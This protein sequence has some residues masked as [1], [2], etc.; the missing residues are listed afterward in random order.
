MHNEITPVPTQVVHPWKAAARTAIQTAVA[1]LVFL[2]TAIP[3]LNAIAPQIADALT[4]ALPEGWGVYL[5]AAVAFIGV[6]AGAVARLMAIPAVNAWFTK[7]K[8]GAA[9]KAD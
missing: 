9:P 8:L 7:L 4:P 3:S 6:V 5:T 2:I 1:L